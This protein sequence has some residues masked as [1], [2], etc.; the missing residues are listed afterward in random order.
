MEKVLERKTVGRYLDPTN[1]LAFKKVFGT[2]EHK[3]SLISFLNAVLSLDGNK[4]ITSVDFLPKE[5]IPI[6]SEGK[7]SVLDVKCTDELGN[8]Y[9]IEMQSRAV[10]DFTKRSQYYASHSYVSQGFSGKRFGELR[11]VVF[12]AILDHLL[13]PEDDHV[14][15]CH[16]TLDVKTNCHRLK[17]IR[18]Y[19]IEL[20][21]FN[22]NESELE[23][24]QDQWIYYFKNWNC[25]R[26]I[27]P[28]IHDEALIEAYRTIE[29]FNWTVAEMDEYVKSNLAR[30]TYEY[31]LEEVRIRERLAIAR[32][33][34]KLGTAIKDI[35]DATGLSEVQ[36]KEL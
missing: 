28:S 14:I 31:E 9:I 2:E 29:K 12:L 1:D 6:I 33:L 17:D 32:K 8:Q 23:T 21:K 7:F 3:P 36:I 19:F 13:F 24:I 20:P 27:P 30:A 22:K 10:K 15:S 26:E 11:P 35:M 5:Q 25:V 4:K 18:Y 34:L 16:H